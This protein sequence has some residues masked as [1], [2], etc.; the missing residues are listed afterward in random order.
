MSVGALFAVKPKINPDE[1]L[2]V[3][4]TMLHV[5]TDTDVNAGTV[6]MPV[7]EPETKLKPVD[8]EPK[9]ENPVKPLNAEVCTEHKT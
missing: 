5:G 8:P 7:S 4:V 3:L 9:P 6:A 1:L 2:F